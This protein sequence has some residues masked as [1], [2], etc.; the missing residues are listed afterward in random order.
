MLFLT[1]SDLMPSPCLNS[2]T[3]SSGPTGRTHFT[4][5][6]STW[7]LVITDQQDRHNM[8]LPWPPLQQ[9]STSIL[10]PLPL[11]W[12]PWR[13]CVKTSS[14]P[15]GQ[16]EPWSLNSC[17]E[18]CPL[19][20][21]TNCLGYDVSRS[22][23]FCAKHLRVYYLSPQHSIHTLTDVSIFFTSQTSIHPADAKGVTLLC[24]QTYQLPQFLFLLLLFT[25]GVF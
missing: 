17:L 22:I 7:G 20:L 4:L 19:L 6:A 25:Q 2:T 9:S 11:P 15:G 21:P 14:I 5:R 12:Q 8:T 23:L 10:L 3:P 16:K 24:E 1:F 18:D 13:L